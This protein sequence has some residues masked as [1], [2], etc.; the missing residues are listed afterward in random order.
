ME[1]KQSLIHPL[2]EFNTCRVTQLELVSVASRLIGELKVTIEEQTSSIHSRTSEPKMQQ[3]KVSTPHERI[4]LSHRDLPS[5]SRSSQ[6]YRG[7]KV[8]RVIGS[9]FTTLPPADPP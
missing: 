9:G 3:D 1:K 7:S 5:T 6:S 8:T 4:A 2:I